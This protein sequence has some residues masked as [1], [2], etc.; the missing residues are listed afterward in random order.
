MK[1]ITIACCWSGYKLYFLGLTGCLVAIFGLTGLQVMVVFA[2]IK[3][4]TWL[5]QTRT[6]TKSPP[7][8]P[9]L[10][11]VTKSLNDLPDWSSCLVKKRNISHSVALDQSH[12]LPWLWWG[13]GASE[14][15][16][17][18]WI[19]VNNLQTPPQTPRYNESRRTTVSVTL[20]WN[21]E[22]SKVLL[23]NSRFLALRTLDPARICVKDKNCRCRWPPILYW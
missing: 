11:G 10:V 17:E 6:N 19:K 20:A 1:K 22:L 5:S 4:Q 3:S 23:Q 8:R 18:K 15:A 2:K 21:D 12:A 14:R 16:Q 13:Q 9:N 7:H